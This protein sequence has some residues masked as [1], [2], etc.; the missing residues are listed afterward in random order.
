M[1]AE[2]TTKQKGDLKSGSGP[3]SWTDN[4]S[5]NAEK[6]FSFV[7]YLITII[8]FIILFISVC[9]LTQSFSHFLTN[10]N[11][12]IIN[13]RNYVLSAIIIGWVSIFII[14]G[15]I[16]WIGVIGFTGDI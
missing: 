3:D 13:A 15:G 6:I 11:V 16:I 9:L 5:K 1:G 14:V 10:N 2:S 4:L 7:H 12:D 8:F